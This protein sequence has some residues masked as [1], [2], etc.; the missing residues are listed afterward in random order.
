MHSKKFKI[1]SLALL[2][3]GLFIYPSKSSDAQTLPS[4][5]LHKFVAYEIPDVPK[6]VKN[7]RVTVQSL[8]RNDSL[9]I[10][11]I[12]TFHFRKNG[13]IKSVEFVN[14]K[15]NEF[16]SVHYYDKFGRIKLQVSVRDD[17]Y[18]FS[19]YNYND[20]LLVTKRFRQ[21]SDG[22]ILRKNFIEY[23][24]NPTLPV[25]FKT[26][27]NDSTLADSTR[28]TF[29]K[30]GDLKTRVFYN[31]PNGGGITIG[32]S[33]TGDKD[34]FTAWPSDTVAYFEYKYDQE[35]N[36]LERREIDSGDLEEKI[37][38]TR[39]KDTLVTTRYHYSFFDGKITSK[40]IEKEFGNFREVTSLGS[41]TDRKYLYFKG[42][43]QSELAFESERDT[44]Y[45]NRK[46][47]YKTKKDDR[48][49]MVELRQFEDGKLIQLVTR[50]IEYWN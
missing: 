16:Y 45:Y 6:S 31:T 27:K 37:V 30:F 43:L 24:S 22:K 8:N 39:K 11:D 49:Q 2:I 29:T 19:R 12:K 40:K 25:K 50:V 13:S 3:L 21:N 20:S 46:Y 15:T 5:P 34:E 48:G 4:Y 47:T 42:Q 28:L 41:Y 26:F 7:I 17:P 10:K 23:S 9:E 1:H 33:I 14:E 32:K 44:T 36:I 18:V 35:G 38:Y